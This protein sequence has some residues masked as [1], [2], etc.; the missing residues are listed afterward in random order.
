MIGNRS[1]ADELPFLTAVADDHLFSVQVGAPGQTTDGDGT[2]KDLGIR[3]LCFIGD[4]SNSRV[5]T[6]LNRT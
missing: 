5:K 2:T 3:E 1:D 4:F 6:S